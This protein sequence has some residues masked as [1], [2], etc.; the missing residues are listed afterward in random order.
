MMKKFLEMPEL[1]NVMVFFYHPLG[2][3]LWTS[4]G[5]VVLENLMTCALKS[6]GIPLICFPIYKMENEKRKMTVFFFVFCKLS[7]GKRK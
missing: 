4:V 3:R 6:G 5:L 2:E 7:K 1:N